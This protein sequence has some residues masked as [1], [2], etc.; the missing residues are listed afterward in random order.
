[1]FVS[2]YYIFNFKECF[3]SYVTKNIWK[4][5]MNWKKI[6]KTFTTP[7]HHL[8]F[9]GSTKKPY[10]MLIVTYTLLFCTTIT[11]EG[12]IEFVILYF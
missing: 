1:M 10:F 8:P 3:D 7:T 5:E 2:S 11:M 6:V 12:T 4:I 9:V